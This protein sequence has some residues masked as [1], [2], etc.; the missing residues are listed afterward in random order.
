M[1]LQRIRAGQQI[2]AEDLNAI[3]E[4]INRLDISV[5]PGLKVQKG[6]GG[7]VIGLDEGPE[8][9]RSSEAG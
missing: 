4:A 3:I 7:I 9:A 5:G 6:A 2:R 1:R 8:E